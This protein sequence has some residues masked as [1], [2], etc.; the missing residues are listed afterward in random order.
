MS[1]LVGIYFP[2]GQIS[3]KDS[4][5]K[6]IESKHELLDLKGGITDDTDLRKKLNQAKSKLPAGGISRTVFVMHAYTT[7]KNRKNLLSIAKEMDF[8]KCGIISSEAAVC[9]S[10]L[11]KYK[12][13]LKEGE[14]IAV[15]TKGKENQTICHYWQKIGSSIKSYI[16]PYEAKTDENMEILKAN[17]KKYVKLVLID[18][19]I[20][21]KPFIEIKLP[22]RVM[23]RD[24]ISHPNF[25]SSAALLKAGMTHFKTKRS[26]YVPDFI[27]T[28]FKI[29]LNGTVLKVI[30]RP[31][32][33][34]KTNIPL[35][36]MKNQNS[37][38]EV[39]EGIKKIE[40]INNKYEKSNLQ[41]TLD[42]NA[43][44]KVTIGPPLTHN[45]R[46]V[47]EAKLKNAL[48]K[49]RA[50]QRV[51][52]VSSVYSSTEE[53]SVDRQFVRW[54]ADAGAESDTEDEIP[55]FECAVCFVT[56]E[57]DEGCFTCSNWTNGDP[58]KSHSICRECLENHAKTPLHNLIPVADGI[59][60][61]EGNC[62][63]VFI[64]ANIRNYL[65]I[66]TLNMLLTQMQRGNLRLAFPNNQGLHVCEVCEHLGWIDKRHPTFFCEC[67]VCKCSTCLRIYD[68]DHLGKTC[69]EAQQAHARRGNQNRS[70][71]ERLSECIIRRCPTCSIQFQKEYG[72]NHMT[73]RC[74]TNMCYLCNAVI[75]G[76]SHFCT[77]RASVSGRCPR[78]NKTCRQFEDHV[79]YDERRLQNIRISN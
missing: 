44:I 66:D 15:L 11:S 42:E 24:N 53:L 79:A 28:N 58:E 34:F 59:H 36:V 14:R 33:P 19:S 27:E 62:N 26:V 32:L 70:L 40:S 51:Q 4:S 76:S 69:V 17:L 50:Q 21:P 60:C 57:I 1:L 30:E 47:A 12:I 29:C 75:T 45:Q 9:I 37:L 39:F 55:S 2:S 72:C 3:W 71:E 46:N 41:F 25:W 20:S 78:C 31:C 22:Y 7:T 52:R 13:H 67:G 5:N 38:I 8:G 56:Y 49:R 43:V 54:E 6:T 77:C 74:G 48:R 68:N 23:K 35:V 10:S 18:A 73:C 61:V 65:S 63:N 64:L 16:K